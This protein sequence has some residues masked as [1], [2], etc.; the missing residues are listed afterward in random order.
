M[1]FNNARIRVLAVA[2]VSLWAVAGTL[3]VPAPAGAANDV[4]A[5]TFSIDGGRLVGGGTVELSAAAEEIRYTL[6]GSVPTLSSPVYTEPIRLDASA[7]LTAIAVDGGR[8]SAPVVEGYVVKSAEKPLLSYVVMSDVHTSV[9]DDAARARWA[10][11]FDTLKRLVPDPDLII[12]NGDQINDNYN[13]TAPDHAV[14]NTLFQE[15]M[16]R[17][18]LSDTPVFMVRGN[19]DTT[20]AQ[21]AK[22]YPE[23]WFPNASGGYYERTIGEHTFLVLDTETYGGAQREWFR[24]RLAAHAAEPNALTK[25][26]FIIGHRPI[27]NTVMQGAQGSNPTLH[28]DL[29]A[30]P[31][32]VFFSGHSHL[33]IHDERSIHQESFT[34]VNDGSMSYGETP[35]DIYQINSHGYLLDDY[36]IATAQALVVDVY[37]DRTEIERIN[38]SAEHERTAVGTVWGIGQNVAPAP[39]AGTLAGP[40]WTVRLEGDTPAAVRANF[41]YVGLSNAQAPTITETPTVRETADGPVLRLPQATDD[42]YVYGYV[43]DVVDTATGAKAL[44]M[45]SSFKVMSDYHFAP[46][47]SVLD[48]PLALR[49]GWAAN[50]RLVTLTYGTAYRATITA[51]DAYGNRSE[52]TTLDFIAG[53]LDRS[54]FD[55]A[56]S[57]MTA[58]LDLIERLNSAATDGPATDLDVFVAELP[59]ALT[60]VNDARALAAA[61][62]ED[63]TQDAV[64]ARTAGLRVLHDALRADIVAVDRAELRAAIAEAEAALAAAETDASASVA[65][66]ADDSASAARAASA[67]VPSGEEAVRTALVEARSVLARLNVPQPEL[68]AA[69][70]AL[71]AA[72]AAWQAVPGAD[73]DADASGAT[74]D[75]DAS[76]AT[77]D[78][79]ASGATADADAAASGAASS[80]SGATAGAQ[81][82][83][84]GATSAG[85]AG[86]DTDGSVTDTPGSDD[87]LAQTGAAAAGWGAAAV[88]ALVLGA[89]GLL[90]SRSA[91]SRR[92]TSEEL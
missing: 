34:S 65:A 70:A 91:R 21:M 8:V 26:L 55:A 31:Q 2:G 19:H 78:A 18:G 59:A 79:D 41:D 33:D 51:V 84:A 47:P 30:Y 17:L 9:L 25:P 77:A 40:R 69:A 11:H 88:L 13:T 37:A 67:D 81:A 57:A 35:R 12:S 85:T 73:A 24:E 27:S 76:G 82:T 44:P 28:S 4:A 22:Y 92:V 49:T 36:T 39:S 14:V 60:R 72:V 74:A 38:F 23:E 52:P 66:G 90:L 29:A 54:D 42:E 3:S 10:G 1:R 20:S 83:S 16:A 71:R 48:I 86:N 7:N 56:W 68:D 63:T 62:S 64:E 61:S 75:A 43:L 5:P 50:D 6:D 80:S 32:A 45:K 87:A 15:N 89:G 53:A 58:D 46:M